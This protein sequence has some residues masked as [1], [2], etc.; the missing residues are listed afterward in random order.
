MGVA[1]LIP[2]LLG[3]LVAMMS[4][5]A[6]TSR[7]DVITRMQKNF[8]AANYRAALVDLQNLARQEPG[9]VDFRLELA[10]SL[11]RTGNFSS[12]E[13]EF[14][15]A[16]Q[17]G[18]AASAVLPGLTEALLGE[19]KFQEALDGLNKER[20]TTGEDATLLKLR[21]Q[22]LLGLGRTSEAHEV[23]LEVVGKAPRDPAA[24]LGLAQTLLRLGDT[25]GAQGELDKANEVDPENFDV[26]LARG[27]WFG[28]QRQ[29]ATARTEFSKALELA[30]HAD[31]RAD[32]ITALALLGEVESAVPDLA[33]AQQHLQQLQKLAPKAGATL[34]LQAR[35]EMQTNHLTE[36]QATLKDLL[37]RDPHS[38]PANVLLG[39]IAGHTGRPEAAESY[40]AA[41]LG[42]QPGNL[43]VRTLLAEAQLAEHRPARALQTAT[44]PRGAGDPALLSL[45]GRASLLEGD[46][47]GGVAYFE[48]SEQA[49]P[50]DKIRSLQVAAAYLAAHRNADALALLQKLDVPDNLVDRREWLLLAA[51]TGAGSTA[52]ARAEAQRFAQARP[53]DLAALLIA[54]G[55]LQAA[56]DVADSRRLLSQAAALDPKS[57]Q[58]SIQLGWLEWS[59]RDYP[60]AERAFVHA[61]ELAPQSNGA[62]LGA[63]Q[64]DLAHGD[65]TA[66]IQKIEQV[67][68]QVPRA[69]PPRIALARLYLSSGELD[70]SAAV[71]S[72]AQALAP[73]NPDVRLLG[74]RLALA[75]GDGGK[76][77]PVLEDLAKQ[78]PKVPQLQEDLARA[79]LLVGRLADARASAEAALRL[80]RDYWPALLTEIDASLG[81]K[82]VH[83]ADAALERLRH[84]RAPQATVLTATGELAARDGKLDEAL[85]SFTAANDIAPSAPLALRIFTIRRAQ[86]TPDPAAPLRT[87]LQHSPSDVVVRVEL[88]EQL[89]FEGQSAGA[90]QEYQKVLKEAPQQL[91]AL[92]NLAWMKLESGDAQAGLDLAR[93]A[94]ASNNGL[95]AVADTYG[96]ALVQ[97][98]HADDAVPLLRNAFG[99]MPGDNEV[100]YHLGV[101]L[102]KTGA[103]KEGRV[104]LQAVAAS[105]DHSAVSERARA[106]LANLDAGGKG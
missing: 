65:R 3:C 71:Y 69:L 17:L 98:G 45:A 2:G 49:A 58:P 91:V 101:A 66:A 44:D 34:L 103:L 32:V 72:E 81:Q 64:A 9:N 84:T 82:D 73:D 89:Q 99:K 5:G 16:R 50:A 36:A 10:E 12:A 68:S 93:R 86:Q 80:D 83:G 33:A 106:L 59:Q 96:W 40:L 102:V 75:R 87:W 15:R 79:E 53:K 8:A 63:A 85:E 56:Q 26:H 47:A 25:S 42:D 51:L 23:W 13:A 54:A 60:A 39:I 90:M 22:A 61:L 46:I 41:A 19:G 29:P 100:R 97:T 55:S 94:Y 27:R 76:A 95:P 24:H 38:E 105:S 70:K 77:T 52:Q 20:P 6:C 74:A 1:P 48:R 62:L 92:N 30:Q 88:A 67:R 31:R 104:E 35:L 14:G 7:Q 78:F 4:I 21:G 57:P 28:M 37:S 18:A 11:L 43:A